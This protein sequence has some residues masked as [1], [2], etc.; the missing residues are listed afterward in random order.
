MVE[1]GST[2]VYIPTVRV[3]DQ[4]QIGWGDVGLE[5][6]RERIDDVRAAIV[7]AANGVAESLS[8]APSAPG[9]EM[10]EVTATFGVSLVAESGV[11]VSK[12]SASASLEV[13]VTFTRRDS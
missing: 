6:L 12:A 10:N 11:I 3:D 1:S 7:S 8:A 5:R 13:S 2:P 4:R 9:W